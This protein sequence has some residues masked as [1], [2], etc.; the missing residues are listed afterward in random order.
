MELVEKAKAHNDHEEK[1]IR[2]LTQQLAAA[3]LKLKGVQDLYT[4][5]ENELATANKVVEMFEATRGQFDDKPLKRD[6]H[7][8]DAHA[9]GLIVACDWHAEETVD[10]KTI[11]NE[12]A[13]NI[14]I[15]E[16]RIHQLWQKALLLIDNVRGL[17]RMDDLVLA[18][19]GDHI[20][21]HIHDELAETNCMSPFEATYWV[22]NQIRHGIRLLKDKSKCKRIRIVCCSGNH[23]RDTKKQRVGTREKHSYE[24]F[25]YKN[26]ADHFANDPVVQFQIADGVL[27]YVNIE[28]R[29]VRLT[30]GDAFKF[31]GGIGGLSV[32]VNRKI[33]QWDKTRRAYHTFF[34][35]WH[36]YGHYGTATACPT[37]KGYDAF[38]E[39]IGAAKES[40]AQLFAVFDSRRGLTREELIFVDKD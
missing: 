37:L 7:S 35:H 38:S 34:G 10:P 3:R 21:G 29:D 16:Q 13:F 40:P 36:Q 11:N 8:K 4:K 23:G 18:L 12:N 15:A 24:W 20:G 27:S 39:W 19:L 9:T 5:A 2:R 1:D 6:K 25:A 14:H 17:T 33:S 26:I 28:G 30:H 22:Q 31:Q 32:P